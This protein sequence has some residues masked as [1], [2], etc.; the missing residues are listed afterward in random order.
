MIGYLVDEIVEMQ[1]QM[2]MDI[3]DIV[4]QTYPN[5]GIASF[6]VY[7]DYIML[8]P[9]LT[10]EHYSSIGHSSFSVC[11]VYEMLCPSYPDYY[12]LHL[13]ICLYLIT[14]NC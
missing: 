11:L 9:I 1:L 2:L 13:L 12:N 14:S 3:N 5:T 6:K 10:Y 8:Q 7:H 4:R